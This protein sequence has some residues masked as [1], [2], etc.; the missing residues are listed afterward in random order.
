MN[1]FLVIIVYIQGTELGSREGNIHIFFLNVPD[2]KYFA[3][4]EKARPMGK[5]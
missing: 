4:L 1:T 5:I 2:A 3:V